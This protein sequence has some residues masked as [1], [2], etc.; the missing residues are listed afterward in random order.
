MNFSAKTLTNIF[1]QDYGKSR[2]GVRLQDNLQD[3]D[4]QLIS[5]ILI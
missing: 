5:E 4:N 2:S 1:V 3:K